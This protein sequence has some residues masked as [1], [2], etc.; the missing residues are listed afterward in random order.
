MHMMLQPNNDGQNH[1]NETWFAS[2]AGAN[3][4]RSSAIAEKNYSTPVHAVLCCQKLP[5]GG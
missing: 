1:L 4:T 2:I 3:V 5:S